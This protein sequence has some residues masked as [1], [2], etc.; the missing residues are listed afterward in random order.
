MRANIPFDTMEYMQ[1]LRNGGM[2][3][4]EAEAFTKATA[5]AFGKAMDDKNVATKSDLNE[6]KSDITKIELSIQNLE[7]KL[8]KSQNEM[9][10]KI[11]GVM[12]A[13]QIMIISL[14]SYAQHFMK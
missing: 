6:L 10:W 13:I 5:K 12:S 4:D 1:E 9:I 8:L 11:L 7:I 14:S 3:Q 2:T